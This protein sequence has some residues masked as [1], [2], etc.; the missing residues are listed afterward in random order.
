MELTRRTAVLVM[1]STLAGC[2]T[3]R[4][5]T[6]SEDGRSVSEDSLYHVSTI[7]ALECGHFSD[8]TTIGDLLENGGFGLGTVDGVDG[9][10][11]IVDGE[12]YAVRGDGSAVEVDPETTTPFAAVT[13]FRSEK[14]VELDSVDSFEAFDAQLTPEL[15]RTDHFYAL[16]ITGEFS[17]LRTRSVEGQ[18]E[19]YPTLEEVLENETI[20][21]FEDTSGD[22]P[23]F[24]I[25]KQFDDIHPPGYH[26]HFV[27]DDR[28]G[29]GHVYDF[30]ANSLTV[31]IAQL[32][33]VTV[34][35]PEREVAQYPPC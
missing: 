22:M 35:L 12:A 30:R 13:E 16:D 8:E 15:P 20:F 21:E 23:T 10:L 27:T 19:P 28:D 34:E 9:E 18:I 17:F 11:A 5:D 2:T 33:S 7:D 24:Y 6:A 26:A 1:I 31:E 3:P 4:G 14:T 29:G 32:E 25:P